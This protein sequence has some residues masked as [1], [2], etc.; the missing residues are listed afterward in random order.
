MLHARSPSSEV[1]ICISFTGSP[2]IIIIY[3]LSSHPA[4]ESST[5][6]NTYG[7]FFYPPWFILS[8]SEGKAKISFLALAE[9]HV[10]ASCVTGKCRSKVV[11]RARWN[12]EPQ[13]GDSTLKKKLRLFIVLTIWVSKELQNLYSKIWF[14]FCWF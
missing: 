2:C 3:T 9:R 12:E 11:V 10:S 6:N 1:I 14:I 13:V 7:I 8:L 5:P 4:K